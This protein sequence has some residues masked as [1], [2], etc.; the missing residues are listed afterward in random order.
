MR[1]L[2]SQYVR[3]GVAVCIFIALPLL[4]FEFVRLCV[5]NGDSNC[6]RLA[7]CQRVVVAVCKRVLHCD[8]VAVGHGVVERLA[9]CERVVVAVI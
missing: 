1:A 3:N 6:E 4:L 9:V 2:D 8:G 5:H 7:V